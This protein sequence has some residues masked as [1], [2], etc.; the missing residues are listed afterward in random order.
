MMP[1]IKK[2]GIIA[3]ILVITVF[4]GT[5]GYN[6]LRSL[7]DKSPPILISLG[8]EEEPKVNTSVTIQIFID[9]ISGIKFCKIYYRIN[10]SDWLS[11]EMRL[12]VILCCPP[13]YLAR[14]GPFSEIYTRI[15][16]YFR[17]A[18]KKDNVLTTDI[19]SFLIQP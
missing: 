1:N 4:G 11:Q 17:I 2:I 6:F 12:Y 14:L 13:R 7:N 16:F 19:Y 18:D 10:S 15:D 5:I 3:L 9:D 8:Y